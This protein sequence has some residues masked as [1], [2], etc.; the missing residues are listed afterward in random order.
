VARIK[1]G[2]LVTGLVAAALITVAALTADASGSPSEPDTPPARPTGNSGP[3]GGA[4]RPAL[5][6][7]SGAGRRV[8]YSLGR[9]R[10]WLVDDDE[11]VLR[12][13]PVAGGDVQ[14]AVGTHL[15][16][17]RRARGAGGDGVDVEHVV[18]F[19]ATDGGNIGFSAPV[20]GSLEPPDPATRTGAVRERRPDAD[21][22]WQR[23]TIGS[24]VEVVRY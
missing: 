19:A 10:V 8:V 6:A 7:G 18:L 13:Y 9:A 21:A 2:T 1:A 14:P 4:G 22:L 17:A 5:P 3:A 20:H 12:T 24:T 11:R 16:F 15:V 23:A